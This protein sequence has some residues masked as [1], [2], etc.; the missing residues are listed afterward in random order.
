VNQVGTSH[1]DIALLQDNQSIMS[2][3][4]ISTPRWYMPFVH[5]I[6]GSHE[7]T[8]SARRAGASQQKNT[9]MHF[10]DISH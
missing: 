6:R 2:V 8:T 9:S 7:H 5:G 1:Q 4:R 3:H 10:F